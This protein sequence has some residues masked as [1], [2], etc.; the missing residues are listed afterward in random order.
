M[1][2]A[3]INRRK[4]VAS[5]LIGATSI[6]QLRSNIASIDVKLSGEVRQRI[7]RVHSRY[8]NPCP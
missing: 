7:D 1:A 4:Y 8:P 2:L 6:E 3:F 5:N